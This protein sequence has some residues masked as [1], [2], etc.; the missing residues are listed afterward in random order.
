VRRIIAIV[1]I[2]L[3]GSLLLSTVASAAD[4]VVKIGTTS[5][6]PACGT[7]CSALASVH[8]ADG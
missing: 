3:I 7:P 1:V 5:D 4:P 6:E 2:T 8:A